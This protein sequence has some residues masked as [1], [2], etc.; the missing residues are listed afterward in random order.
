[1]HTTAEGLKANVF[2]IAVAQPHGHRT[3]RSVRFW[4]FEAAELW[5]PG[6]GARSGPLCPDTIDLVAR[7]RLH[8]AGSTM[9]IGFSIDAPLLGELLNVPPSGVRKLM[10]SNEITTRR[11]HQ[12]PHA[13]ADHVRAGDLHGA[14]GPDAVTAGG[15]DGAAG[16]GVVPGGLPRF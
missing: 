10:L 15:V 9:T 11:R 1:M 6:T 2:L 14:A 3:P 5:R 12:F 13:A 4:G 7:R 16:S 8:Y